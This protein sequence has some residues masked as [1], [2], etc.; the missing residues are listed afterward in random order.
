[1]IF[2]VTL[3]SQQLLMRPGFV[4]FFPT[5]FPKQI[6]PGALEHVHPR[7]SGPTDGHVWRP[8]HKPSMV[9]LPTGVPC[10]AP[11]PRVLGSFLAPKTTTSSVTFK[12]FESFFPSHCFHVISAAATYRAKKFLI[13]LGNKARAIASSDKS[14]LILSMFMWV[15]YPDN[16]P[17]SRHPARQ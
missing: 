7:I 12:S 5:S 11:I 3:L 9:G 1:M 2:G 14:F 6:G 8:R 4:F 17:V 15:P 16:S 10:R 13:Y